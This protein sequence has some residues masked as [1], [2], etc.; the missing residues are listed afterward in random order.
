MRLVSEAFARTLVRLVAGAFT[1]VLFLLPLH[2]ATL[3]PVAV[4]GG[5][6][7][8]LAALG[9]ATLWRWMVTAAA[10]VFLVDYTVA[11]WIARAPVSVVGA[12]GFGLS[13]LFLFQAVELSRCLRDAE[14]GAGVYRSQIVGWMGFGAATLAATMLVVALA[15]A[16]AASVPFAAAPIVAAVAAAGVVLAL[17]ATM[18]A[19]RRT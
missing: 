14:I 8:L 3:P 15:G 2:T 7:L 19:A 6:G 9:I 10:C 16:A 13:L 1:L 17:A 4:I 18:K 12:A 5:T 11:L